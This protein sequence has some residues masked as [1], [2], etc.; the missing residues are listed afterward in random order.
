MEKL[1]VVPFDKYYSVFKENCNLMTEI[2][3]RQQKFQQEFLAL[4]VKNRELKV[5]NDRLMGSSKLLKLQ[6]EN[7]HQQFLK[8]QKEVKTKR[9]EA[10]K[11]AE[12]RLKLIKK[13]SEEHSKENIKFTQE[14]KALKRQLSFQRVENVRLAGKLELISKNNTSEDQVYL[15]YKD[16][17]KQESSDGPNTKIRSETRE[18]QSPDDSS[19]TSTDVNISENPNENNFKLQIQHLQG[20]INEIKDENGQLHLQLTKSKTLLAKL[21]QKWKASRNHPGQQVV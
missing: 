3:Q 21:H 17:T 7:W 19:A 13:D 20:Q 11:K 6:A 8:L 9:D 10:L 16:D 14:I 12:D 15:M 2:E 1:Q 18:D 5:K 4:E